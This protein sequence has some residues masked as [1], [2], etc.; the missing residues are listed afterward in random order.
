MKHNFF[1][2]SFFEKLKNLNKLLLVPLG[3]IVNILTLGVGQ[4]WADTWTIAGDNTTVLGSSW[5][6]DATDNDMIQSGTNWFL[7][8]H[9]TFSNSGTI[10][11]KAC[12]DHAWTTAYGANGNASI[13]YTSGTKDIIFV[14]NATDLA[15]G[16]ETDFWEVVARL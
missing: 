8:K 7:I 5:S 9:V 6:A 16:T 12:K 14:T 13:N 1:K 15:W 3:L 4:M 10:E 11:F 2:S